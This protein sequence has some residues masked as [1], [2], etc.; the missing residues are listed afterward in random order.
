MAADEEETE[1]ED[2]EYPRYD[3]RTVTKSEGG[4]AAFLINHDTGESWILDESLTW[5]PIRRAAQSVP[6]P[7]E[8]VKPA[9]PAAKAAPAPRKRTR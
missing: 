6:Q 8:P 5:Q 1:C 4:Y 7:A 9:R 2:R 3:I